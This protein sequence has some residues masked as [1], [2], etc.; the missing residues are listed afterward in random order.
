[1]VTPHL[2]SQMSLYS[3]TQM[4]RQYIYVHTTKVKEEL[5]AIQTD[6]QQAERAV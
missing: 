4:T 1:M 5:L 3:H 6:F 2:Y